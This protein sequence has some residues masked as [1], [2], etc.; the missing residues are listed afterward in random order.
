MPQVVID[1]M[2]DKHSGNWVKTTD[3]VNKKYSTADGTMRT[4]SQ[5]ELKVGQWGMGD[6][7]DFFYFF[8]IEEL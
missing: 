6:Y 3:L 4:F 2:I 5:V 8:G 7:F 1:Y